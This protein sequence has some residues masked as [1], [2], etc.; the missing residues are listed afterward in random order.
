MYYEVLCP[1]SFSCYCRLAR[2][3]LIM[4]TLSTFA[5]C[6]VYRYL[7]F[8]FRWYIGMIQ[9]EMNLYLW[10]PI[11]SVKL[12]KMTFFLFSYFAWFYLEKGYKPIPKPHT[13]TRMNEF[14][15]FLIICNGFILQTMHKME[16]MQ[17]K[18]F[19]HSLFNE[20]W[21]VNYFGQDIEI[22]WFENLSNLLIEIATIL[23][24]NFT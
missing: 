7:K 24:L 18:M 2:H 12:F 1:H 22:F 15:E 11:Y 14:Y 6:N 3:E 4:M 19:F 17:L 20:F 10:Y 21:D 9:H 5:K 16:L 23:V 13:L 8:K